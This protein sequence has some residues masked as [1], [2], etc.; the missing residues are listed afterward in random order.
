[1]EVVKVLF[2]L[3]CMTT[4]AAV[5]CHEKIRRWWCRGCPACL[6]ELDME[7]KA[8]WAHVAVKHTCWMGR[9]R[10]VL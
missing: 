9:K 7:A 10:W 1:M 3:G 5:V 6:L 8:S 2:L 4:L